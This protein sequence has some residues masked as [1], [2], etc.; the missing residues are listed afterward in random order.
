MRANTLRQ[1]S[2]DLPSLTP[3]LKEIMLDPKVVEGFSDRLIDYFVDGA[4]LVV[5]GG[6]RGKDHRPK[7]VRL[8]HHLQMPLVQRGLTNR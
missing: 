1:P 4:G 6:N 7:I 8:G 3:P 2:P 5:E